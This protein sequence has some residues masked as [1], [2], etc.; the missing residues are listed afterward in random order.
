MITSGRET[1]ISIRMKS[2]A[3]YLKAL[4]LAPTDVSDLGTVAIK[5]ADCETILDSESIESITREVR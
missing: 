3:Q 1:P 5:I 4:V 2:G